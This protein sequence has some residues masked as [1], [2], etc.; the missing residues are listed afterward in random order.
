[1]ALWAIYVANG[2]KS[3]V[4]IDQATFEAAQKRAADKLNK[5]PTAVAAHYDAAAHKIVVEL[6]SGLGL[7]FSPKNV[8]GLETASPSDL[9]P[10]SIAPFGLGLHFPK[11]D[12]DVYLPSLL[13]GLLGSKKWMAARMGAAGGKATTAAKAQAAR[14]NG[15]KGGRP[16]KTAATR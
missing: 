9:Q 2:E 14:V 16:R 7:T 10:I 3:M 1:M 15:A 11:L 8:Q 13:D 4:E 12:A 5:T 6:S